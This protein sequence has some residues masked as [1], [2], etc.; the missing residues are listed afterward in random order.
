VTGTNIEAPRGVLNPLPGERTFRLT[1]YPP[2]ED[3]GYFVEHYYIF[4][5]DLRGKEPCSHEALP[6]P[7]VN[8]V[9]E[10][11]DS[12]IFGVV[13]GKFSRTLAGEGWVFGAKFKP[14]GFYPFVEWPI[15]RLTDDSVGLRDLFGER[16]QTLEKEI[17]APRNEAKLIEIAEMFLRGQ[18]PER[19]NTV[20]LIGRVVDC[21]ITNP[22]ITRV[23]D[24]VSRLGLSKRTLQR[25][26][27]RYVGVSPK[28]VIRRYRL[29]EAAER[30]AVGKAVSL[31]E[32]ALDLG[33]FDQAHFIKD[34]KR[35][36]GTTPAK[37]ASGASE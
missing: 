25:I 17:L 9:I 32:V 11:G 35:I 33:Y 16:G 29:H 3:L 6:H 15:S 34:F 13:Q 30:L 31:P 10:R 14:G 26:F 27:E 28:W 18:S 24:V 8:L 22:E 4:E 19:D 5:W 36:V 7:S 37:Y 2:S 1:R 23:D 21:I 20:E 12:R